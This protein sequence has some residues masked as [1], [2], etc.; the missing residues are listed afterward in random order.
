MPITNAAN[1]WWG[2]RKDNRM[3]VPVFSV[4]SVEQY[5]GVPAIRGNDRV[6]PGFTGDLSRVGRK[7]DPTVRSLK[8]R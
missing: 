7:I 1:H 8:R 5:S 6:V 3:G 2:P 4:P